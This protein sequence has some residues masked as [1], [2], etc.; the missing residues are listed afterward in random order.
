MANLCF[1]SFSKIPDKP[2]TQATAVA[3]HFYSLLMTWGQAGSTEHKQYRLPYWGLGFG[4]VGCVCVYTRA[5]THMC[6]FWL[7]LAFEILNSERKSY[8][9][10]IV[11][12]D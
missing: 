11:G 10:I 6:A 1:C 9:G 12:T 3:V 8:L 4:G 7:G 5:H 2:M